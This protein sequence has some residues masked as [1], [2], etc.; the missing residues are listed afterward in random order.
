MRT[1]RSPDSRS[2]RKPKFC[3][4]NK[5]N[6]RY[7]YLKFLNKKTNPG[8]NTNGISLSGVSKSDEM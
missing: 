2:C 6:Y 4:T 7:M 3:T 1:I 8:I 5:H